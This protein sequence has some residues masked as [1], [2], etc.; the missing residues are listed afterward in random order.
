MSSKFKTKSLKLN[1]IMNA[2]LT[3]SSFIF[4]LITY[5]YISR[6]LLP[7]GTGKVS[8]ASSIISYFLMFSHLGIPTYG[9]RMC[10]KVRDDKTKLSKIV[11]DIVSINLVFSFISYVVLICMVFFVPRFAEEKLLYFVLSISI[12]LSTVGMEWL[13]KGLEQYSYITIRSLLLKVV[14]VVLMYL[15]VHSEGDYIIYAGISVF[16][17]SA[18]YLLNL[19]NSRKYVKLKLFSGVDWKTHIRPIIVFFAMSVAISIY[20]NLDTIMLGFMKSDTEVGYY[21][22]A[23]KARMMLLTVVT[24]LGTVLLP[25]ASYYIQHDLLDEF[26]KIIKK[27]ANF[28][29][30][31]SVPLTV[32]FV[33][34]STASVL[35]LSGDAY[36]NAVPAMQVIMPTLFLV[37]LSN[38]TGI[39]VLIPMGNENIVLY[40]EIA[41]AVVDF[42][43]NLALIPSLGVI[44]AAIGTLIAEFV[45]LIVQCVYLRKDIAKI[46]KEVALLKI[47]IALIVGVVASF[48]VRTVGFNSFITLL[49]SSILFFCSY[50]IV[51]LFLKEKFVMSVWNQV[52]GAIKRQK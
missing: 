44:G 16:A 40:S 9:V 4:P 29:F 6:V 5:P 2:F 37:G 12:I 34:Y 20:T 27:S 15:L 48:W 28:I 25:R 7:E 26:W 52:V 11:S 39:Q 30:V 13:Y 51:L 21:N 33:I 19:F 47:I 1:F 22:V 32:Y 50:G 42:I 17:S 24:S 49:I 35:L 45:V 3:M 36:L 14:S 23:I 31:F 46:F 10:A 41:G 8:F 38:I 43:V 18:S